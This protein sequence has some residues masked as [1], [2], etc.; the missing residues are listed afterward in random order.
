MASWQLHPQNSKRKLSELRTLLRPGALIWNCWV[1]RLPMPMAICEC[2][3]E[4]K[5]YMNRLVRALAS[6]MNLLDTDCIVLRGGLNYVNEIYELLPTQ[7]L[8]T[9]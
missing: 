1:Q 6:E 7:T 5:R 4:F 8:T 2:A 3:V 9:L